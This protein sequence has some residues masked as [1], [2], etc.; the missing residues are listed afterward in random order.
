MTQSDITNVG[1][2]CQRLAPFNFWKPENS[3]KFGQGV[4]Q[5]KYIVLIK[6]GQVSNSCYIA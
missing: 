4:K 5:K 6:V 1:V 2:R 3:A